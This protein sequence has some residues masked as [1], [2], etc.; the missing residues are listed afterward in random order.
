M[1]QLIAL[2]GTL[3][4]HG[5]LLWGIL[6][7][8][9]QPLPPTTSSTVQEIDLGLFITAEP[10]TET[11]IPPVANTPKQAKTFSQ[12]TLAEQTKTPSKPT[13]AEPTKTPSKPTLAEPTKTPA[14]PTLINKPN[15][16]EI[17]TPL[18]QKAVKQPKKKKNQQKNTITKRKK[19][20]NPTKKKTPKKQS[21]KQSKKHTV[22]KRAHKTAKQT[23]KKSV[24]KPTK[25]VGEAAQQRNHKPTTGKSHSTTSASQSKANR[26]LFKAYQNG[27]SKKIRRTAKRYQKNLRSRKKGVVSVRFHLSR[28]GSISGARIIKSSGHKALDNAAIKII[29]RV[30]KHQPPPTGYPSQITIPINFNAQR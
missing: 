2:L 8:L 5:G 12:P 26:R 1:R 13:L 17:P 25:T 20:K 30:K 10:H 19:N 21:K 28:N 27:L 23:T 4:L 22:K 3:V 24:P 18:P 6:H 29:N 9:E 14:K 11:T 15:V 7:L 16:V